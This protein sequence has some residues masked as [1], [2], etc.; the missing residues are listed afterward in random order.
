MFPGNGSSEDLD[1][2]SERFGDPDEEEETVT[3]VTTGGNTESGAASLHV[4][5]VRNQYS[6]VNRG[7]INQNF[8]L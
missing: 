6:P 8:N 2:F 3:T 1:K 5:Q 7:V 4:S